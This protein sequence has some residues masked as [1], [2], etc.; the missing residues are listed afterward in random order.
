MHVTKSRK[1]NILSYVKAILVTKSAFLIFAPFFSKGLLQRPSNAYKM[2]TIA[3]QYYYQ[4]SFLFK[5]F[6]NLHRI[7]QNELNETCT[8]KNIWTCFLILSKFGFLRKPNSTKRHYSTLKWLDLV[9]QVILSHKN[10]IQ[11]PKS[12]I[13][14]IYELK[15]IFLPSFE[16]CFS[17]PSK[18]K[19][20]LLII[21]YCLRHSQ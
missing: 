5:G 15:C 12:V 21:L 6:H 7:S 8:I 3:T 16:I 4:K 13:W 20:N 10:Q 1:E 14:S 17:F 2:L 19:W 9:S 11:T 18:I